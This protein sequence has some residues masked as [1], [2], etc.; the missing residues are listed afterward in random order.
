MNKSSGNLLAEWTSYVVHSLCNPWGAKSLAF[1]NTK[2]RPIKFYQLMTWLGPKKTLITVHIHCTSLNYKVR[3]N[4]LWALVALN[5]FAHRNL[6]LAWRL[7]V[8]CYGH[9]VE[10]TPRPAC[11]IAQHVSIDEISQA[12]VAAVWNRAKFMQ[13]P[14]KN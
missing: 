5:V 4:D 10:L 6:T 7:K 8:R 11:C 13:P 1:Y 9:E 14:V 2:F 12:N 3:K